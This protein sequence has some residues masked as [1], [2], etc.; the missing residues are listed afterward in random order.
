MGIHRQS[1]PGPKIRTWGTHICWLAG[2][3]TWGIHRW[4]N[5][6]LSET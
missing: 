1:L 6:K 3:R 2:I 5:F 4:Y